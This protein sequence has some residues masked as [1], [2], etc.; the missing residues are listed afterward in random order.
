M[1]YIK[2]IIGLGNPGRRFDHTRHNIGFAIVDA[3]AEK[4]HGSWDKKGNLEQ[5]R[6]IINDQPLLLIKPQTFM[7]NSGEI[8]P[9]LIK[10]GIKTENVL[11]IHDELEKPFGKIAIK[12]GGSHRGHN[13]LRSIIE[14]IG[15]DFKRLRFGIGRPER[16]EDVSDYVL[17]RFNP[18]EMA[19]IEGLIKQAIE[20]IEGNL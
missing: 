7:N 5:A 10:Q 20:M 19:Q 13:G 16:K 6:I 15:K 1:S 4:Y 14:H 9:D 2:A 18:N 3:L 8:F 12:E 11:I 17:Q